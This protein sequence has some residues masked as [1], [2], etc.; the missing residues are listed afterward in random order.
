MNLPTIHSGL[1]DWLNWLLQL[2]AQEIELGLDRVREVAKQLDVLTPA[3]YVI[4]V[5]GTNGKGSSVAMLVAILSAAGYKVGSYTSPHI[6]RFNERIQLNA[7]PVSDQQIVVAFD[8]I[9][10]ARQGIKLT[11]FEFATLAALVLFKQS[12]LDIVVL[13]V[14]LGGRL[15]AVNIVDAQACLLTAIDV[16]HIE[17]L[18]SD[19]EKIGFEKAGIMRS[20][21]LTVCSDPNPPKTVVDYAEKL[22]VDL[23][24]LG[25]DYGFNVDS[26]DWVFKIADQSITLPLPNL[27]GL[28]QLQN[29]AGVLA[30]L[31][32]QARLTIDQVA[33]EQGLKQIQH[34]GRLQ[35]IQ[36]DH[37]AWLLDVAHNSQSVDVL[38]NHLKRQPEQTKYLV[39][40]S[41]LAD[42]DIEAMVSQIKPY[43]SHW[44][45]V[46]LQVERSAPLARLQEVLRLAG[47]GAECQLAFNSMAEAVTCARQ[48]N[49]S[50]VLIYGSF[51]T[52][53]QAMAELTE[54]MS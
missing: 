42:K 19:R 47:V 45:L 28:F 21:G 7:Q 54:W 30:L 37:Q 14:G 22:H 48:S 27:A 36:L 8:R 50:R 10:K 4:T 26:D 23:K 9:E 51:V 44:L 38:A 33:Y 39:V 29:A 35:T 6:L 25:R 16:D 31:K 15:D 20:N 40:F 46:D 1:T 12:A 52:V 41:A 18:G 49:E 24:L 53:S 5:A 32:T 34:P 11:Y 2:H 13:E 3:P 17:W 43:A